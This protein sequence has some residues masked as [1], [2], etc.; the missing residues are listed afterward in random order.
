MQQK[1][2]K[3]HLYISLN[4]MKKITILFI[5]TL[6][7]RAPGS[8]AQPCSLPGMTPS[9]AIPVCGTA[10]FSQDLVTDCTGPDIAI[11][12]C[13]IGVTSSKSFWYK[14]TCFQSG[15]LGFLIT[16]RSNTDDY[17]WSLLDVTGRNPND[18]FTNNSLQVSLNIYGTGGNGSGAPFPNSPTGCRASGSGDVH[19]EGDA[20]GNSPFN[21]M[22]N[23][24][25]G[26]EYLLMV[27]NWTTGSTQGYDLSFSGGT[28]SITDPL[29]PHLKTAS[30]SCDGTQV[31]IK[32]NKKMK[33]SS[34]ATDGSDFTINSAGVNI[35]GATGFGCSNGFDMDSVLL[36]LNNPLAPGNYTITMRNGADANTL[37]DNC[38]RLVPVGE[39]IPLTVFPIIPTPMD[40]LTKIGC[41]PV[42]LQLVFKKPMQCG[43]IAPDG[44]DFRV[45][46]PAAVTVTAAT[47]SCSGGLS[48][49]I[50]VQ[51]SSPLQL[52]GIYTILLQNGS[53]GNTILD[54]CS[55]QT[56]AGSSIS[57]VVSDTVNANFTYN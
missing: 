35:I 31:K 36:T 56:P 16:G 11:R 23:L 42:V 2:C 9:S 14:F 50:S 45:T 34:L 46:G 54:E 1:D 29:E 52:G 13:N 25:A 44:S 39:N 18:V 24:I 30:A 55:Q 49:V 12:G 10:V 5:L 37:K 19:C 28:A 33:C 43:S 17:D 26:H 4:G 40:S 51:L 20:S 38:D 3:S 22:P 8:F 53:D 47:G 15:T 32:L 41:A 48:S 27:T 6:L 7:L 57:F 21:R